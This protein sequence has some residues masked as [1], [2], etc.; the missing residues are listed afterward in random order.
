MEQT[1]EQMQ[2][3]AAKCPYCYKPIDTA[4]KAQIIDRGYDDVRRKQYVRQREMD[5]CSTVCG[6]NYQMGCEG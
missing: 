2:Q 4:V 3:Q 1:I 5:F 6:S